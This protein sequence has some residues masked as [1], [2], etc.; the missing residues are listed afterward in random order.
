ML[1]DLQVHSTYSDGYLTPMELAKFLAKQGVK[2]AA[3]TDHN[4]V[5]GL[6]Q[7]KQ[8]SRAFK[9]KAIAGLELY[10]KLNNRRFNLLW[11]NFDPVSPDLHNLL[12]QS[13]VRRR[14]RMRLILEKFVNRGFKL[15][16]NKI[17]DKYTHYVP[18]NR[19]IE[20]II[21]SR[22]NLLKIKKHLDGDL[23]REEEIIRRLF[24]KK[25]IGV[26]RE[27]YMSIEKVFHLRK[28]I[29]GQLILGH[30]ARYRM[31]KFELL[32]KFKKMGLDGVEIFSPHHTFS[33]IMAMQDMAHR[34]GFI[35]TGGS[36]FHRPEGGYYLVQDAW[37]Y[38]K[39]DARYL[40]K[41]EKIIS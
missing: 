39:I 8:A 24:F 21:A 13:Q 5:S 9:I 36:D 22:E 6:E 38:F 28:K 11:Y 10:V 40:A 2:V 29:G 19:V 18:I 25:E 15:G 27:S 33:A 1:I 26:L 23:M 17:L 7:F 34:L 4:T 3:L 31:P 30:P 37:Q 14:Q 12:R 35:E 41:I 20:D 16:I 32:K